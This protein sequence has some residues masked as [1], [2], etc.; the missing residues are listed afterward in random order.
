[1][2]I[3]SLPGGEGP[4]NAAAA[5]GTE[6]GGAPLGVSDATSVIESPAPEK[7]HHQDDDE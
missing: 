1:M 6:F 3:L 5:L 7:Q 4:P 2:L